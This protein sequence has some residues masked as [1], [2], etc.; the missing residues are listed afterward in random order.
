MWT[1]NICDN[2]WHAV[3][4]NGQRAP[5]IALH[6]CN[7]VY[8]THDDIYLGE[9]DNALASY[10]G[11]HPYRLVVYGG[12][13][14]N[15]SVKGSVWLFNTINHKWECLS[16]T[17]VVNAPNLTYAHHTAIYD[18]ALYV[19]GGYH[20]VVGKET[21]KNTSMFRF[22]F[23]NRKWEEITYPRCNARLHT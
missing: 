20:A 22:C 10:N 23:R 21:E 11:S 1:Y 15:A 2:S 13:G 17:E 3:N 16:D 9:D 8:V 6:S 18:N 5:K 14:S 7:G 4:V 19:C 12:L